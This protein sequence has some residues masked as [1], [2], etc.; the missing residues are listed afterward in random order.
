MAKEITQIKSDL[1][2]SVNSSTASLPHAVESE[3]P[4]KSKFIEHQRTFSPRM[5]NGSHRVVQTKSKFT[6]ILSPRNER[7]MSPLARGGELLIKKQHKLML[8][9]FN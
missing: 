6:D 8:E 2:K 5:A 3:Q 7:M 4:A 9:T 1:G